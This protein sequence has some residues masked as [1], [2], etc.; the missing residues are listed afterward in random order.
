[1][2]FSLPRRT[3]RHIEAAPLKL[4]IVQVRY[5]P[6]LAV[7]QAAHVAD[8]QEGLGPAYDLIDSQKAHA[9]TVYFGPGGMEPPT[10]PAGE[11]IW[12]FRRRDNAWLVALS[13]S[14]LGFEAAEYGVFNEFFAEFARVLGVFQERFVPSTQTRLGMRYVNEIEEENLVSEGLDR[15]LNSAL[16]APV[17]S[18]LGTD[19]LSSLSDLRFRQPDGVF[20]LRH[21]LIRPD[22][23]LLDFDYF[24]EEERPF[25]RQDIRRAA[26]GF[27]DVIESM[28]IWSLSD[29]YLRRLEEGTR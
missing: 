22:A 2:P 1:L 19:L 25:D 29:E 6:I 20:A 26:A 21:G 4:A 16:V 12:R 18:D 27:H 28:F 5:H 10:Q 7:E 13:S 14:S 3:L 11:T 17:G 8:F 15:F 9:L 23:Y 24:A